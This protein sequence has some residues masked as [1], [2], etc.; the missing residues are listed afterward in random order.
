MNAAEILKDNKARTALRSLQMMNKLAAE[1]NARAVAERDGDGYYSHNAEAQAKHR[2]EE[3]DRA[4][5]VQ[6]KVW[7]M[8][9]MEV[10][11]LAMGVH[12]IQ[13]PA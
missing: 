2:E 8:D 4:C 6:A 1:A 12:K 9:K 13:Q 7:G 5:E 3:L 10:L 11:A